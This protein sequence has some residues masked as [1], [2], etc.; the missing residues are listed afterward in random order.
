MEEF[1]PPEYVHVLEKLVVWGELA[2]GLS[3]LFFLY[4]LLQNVDTP[5][6]SHPSQYFGIGP[7]SPPSYL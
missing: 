5:L 6:Y 7:L 4:P 2:T 3:E 1:F